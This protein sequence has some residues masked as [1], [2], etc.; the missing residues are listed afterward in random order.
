[1]T[2]LEIAQAKLQ[3]A[4]AELL[5]LREFAE[6]VAYADPITVYTLPQL[7][8]GAQNALFRGFNASLKIWEDTGLTKLEQEPEKWHPR[9]PAAEAKDWPVAAETQEPEADPD[10]FVSHDRQKGAVTI[11]FGSYNEKRY[12]KPWIARV[13]SW[14]IGG[15]ASVE[16]GNFL[17][18][19]GEA[20]ECE[21]E[22]RIG[23]IIRYGQKDNRNPRHTDANWGVVEPDFLIRPVTMVEARKLYKR[24]D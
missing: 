24:F 23:D 9:T 6:V 7:Q 13:F 8:Q 21:I 16:W 12:S 4:A 2:E 20:G 19:P 18:G 11:K 17:G 3:A 1:M 14:P 5:M 10:S 22:A 15:H